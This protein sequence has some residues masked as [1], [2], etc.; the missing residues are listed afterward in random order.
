MIGLSV[1]YVVA[2]V[3]FSAFAIL[4]ALDRNN[5]KRFGNAAFWAL[6]A[7]SFLAG[8]RLG[9]VGNGI[10]V[11]GLA[12][13]A[14]LGGL[15]RGLPATTSTDERKTSAERF[16]NRLF[17]P[18]LTLPLVVVFGVLVLKPLERLLDGL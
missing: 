15:G 13:I 16:G 8:D 18:A 2:G 5:R 1:V 12:A 17:I 7:T 11:L 6:V 3:V 9:D 10:V 4:S 14:G